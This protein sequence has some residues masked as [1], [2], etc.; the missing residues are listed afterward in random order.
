M[1]NKYPQYS[2]V[3]ERDRE[4]ANLPLSNPGNRAI[5]VDALKA[6]LEMMQ[7]LEWPARRKLYESFQ[8]G[9]RKELIL[10]LIK[11]G[12]TGWVRSLSSA[13][14]Q[15]DPTRTPTQETK[16]ILQL[17]SASLQRDQLQK[18]PF[19][20]QREVRHRLVQ[21]ANNSPTASNVIF[22]NR[23]KKDAPSAKVRRRQH[24]G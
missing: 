16:R 21:R 11:E 24:R 2:R 6:T 3:T 22:K 10:Y 12:R 1:A 13:K 9:F 14:T 4:I 5:P 15:I 20:M 7:P 23:G 8:P 18:L 19:R 17:P